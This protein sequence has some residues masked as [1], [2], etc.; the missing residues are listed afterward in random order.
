MKRTT[1]CSLS[2]V[3]TALAIEGCAHIPDHT[4]IVPTL[5]TP[6]PVVVSSLPITIERVDLS[7][8]A[9]TMGLPDH[10][11]LGGNPHYDFYER[12]DYGKCADRGFPCHW[13][14]DDGELALYTE[15]DGN[16]G[17]SAGPFGVVS[18][19]LNPVLL[20]A[21]AKV[22][23]SMENVGNDW[24]LRGHGSANIHLRPGSDTHCGFLNISVEGLLDNA[25]GRLS[26]TVTNRINAVRIKVPVQD[27]LNRATGPIRLALPDSTQACIYPN[28]N[29]VGLGALRGYNYRDV[30]AD[31]QHSVA[32]LRSVDVPIQV[33]G[34]PTLLITSSDC[35]L[36]QPTQPV[37]AQPPVAGQSFRVLA[38]VAADYNTLSSVLTDEAKKHVGHYGWLGLEFKVSSATVRDAQGQVLVGLTFTGSLDGTI[39][40]WGSPVIS[41]D[42]KTVSIPDVDLAVES[43]NAL[44]GIDAS[45]PSSI[46]NLFKQPLREKLMVNVEQLTLPLKHL[47]HVGGAIPGG[48]FR[49][50]EFT[51]MPQAVRSIPSSLQID[52]L[53]TGKAE[54]T[55]QDIPHF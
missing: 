37:V 15:F 21:W 8:I 26:D 33:T 44:L 35:P 43:R 52:V 28:I 36:A 5:I 53:L 30:D 2:F 27:V 3:I 29:G 10:V 19:N 46:T 17:V 23:P 40:F 9:A 47:A 31:G 18:C 38:E 14:L 16:A 39:Y 49:I 55:I 4:A 54:A 51:L 24:F 20:A 22:S 42:G 32:L 7:P 41:A 50:D 45:L 34:S 12:S 1:L 6:K 25:L 11:Q 13:I 48:T